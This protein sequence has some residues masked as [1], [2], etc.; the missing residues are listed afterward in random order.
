MIKNQ[1][2]KERNFVGIN[3]METSQK[4]SVGNKK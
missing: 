4:L 1:E 3:F 2:I